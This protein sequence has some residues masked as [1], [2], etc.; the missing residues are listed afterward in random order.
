MNE[1]FDR[2]IQTF[3]LCSML[4]LVAFTTKQCTDSLGS[5]I[6]VIQYDGFENACEAQGGVVYNRRC[7]SAD[8]LISV[9]INND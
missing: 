9:E 7:F 5:N 2:W 3:I 8:S 4:G 1:R 6:A